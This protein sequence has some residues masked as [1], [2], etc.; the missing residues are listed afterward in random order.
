MRRG[1]CTG[2]KRNE[3]KRKERDRDRVRGW[4]GGKA[5]ANDRTNILKF[6]F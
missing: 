4:E 3:R 5:K 2:R 6:N 1:A